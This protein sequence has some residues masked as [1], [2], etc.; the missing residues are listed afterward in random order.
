MHANLGWSMR[1]HD[2]H[3][4]TFPFRDILGSCDLLVAANIL[5]CITY[6]I[7]RI[8]RISKKHKLQYINK[9]YF[10]IQLFTITV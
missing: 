8:T 2:K 10:P 4:M 7:R 6:I 3:S 1:K 9:E 5:K